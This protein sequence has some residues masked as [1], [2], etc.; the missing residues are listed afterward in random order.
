M[1][2]PWNYKK[3][4]YILTWNLIHMFEMGGEIMRIYVHIVTEV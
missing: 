3:K 2:L 4:V 1:E